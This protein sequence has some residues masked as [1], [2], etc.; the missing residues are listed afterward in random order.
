MYRP[1]LQGSRT[2]PCLGKEQPVKIGYPCK[3][4]SVGCV[5]SKT[6]RL[7]SYSEE[8]LVA[9]V[10]NNLHCL[11]EM[12][13]FN[14]AHKVLFFRVTS[15]LV[16]FAS[17]PVCR[18]DWREV[19]KETFSEIGTFIRLHHMRISMHPDQFTLINSRDTEIFKRS[20]SELLYHAGVLDALG[21][22][23]T[24]KIQIHVGGL[25]SDRKASVDRFVERFETLDGAIKKRLVVEND[26]TRFTLA[27]CAEVSRLT[28]LPVVFDLFHHMLLNRGEAL[29]DALH[30]A[31]QTWGAGDGLPIVD[32]SLQKPGGRKGKHA[33]HLEEKGFEVFLEQTGNTDFD[34]MLEIKDKEQS[35]LKAV[36]IAATDPRFVTL[37][38]F[39]REG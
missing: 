12:L 14:A 16:P 37:P 7:K 5:G 39:Q 23:D 15:D 10:Q 38:G 20:V 29:L 33:Q 32:Y 35:A 8:R 26:D 21:L 25:Y 4:L 28:G 34:L 27:D 6:F 17:H 2:Y 24:A 18:L 9:T 19:F 30:C 13:Q 3:N 1:P 36:S 31:S 22:D 11:L